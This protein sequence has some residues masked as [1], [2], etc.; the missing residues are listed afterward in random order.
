MAANRGLFLQWEGKR[1]YRQRI[2]TPRL[3][4]P[5]AEHSFGDGANMVIEGDNLQ[6]LAS[7]K[8]QYAGA[9]KLIYA[10]PP[11][12]TGQKDFR[13][14]DRRFH[15][16]DADDNDAV[17]VTNEDGGR[18]TKWLNYMAPRLSLLVDLL[19]P[20]GAVMVSIDDNEVFRLGM[21]MD[22]IFGED[23]HVATFIW[24][25]HHSRN[26]T[27]KHVAVT[28]DYILMY[29]KDKSQL[30]VRHVSFEPGEFAN[31]DNDPKGPW[32]SRDLS[33]NH[34]YAGGRYK[35]K[36]PGGRVFGPTKGRYWSLTEENFWDLHKAK[37]IWWGKE[38]NSRPR[39]KIYESELDDDPEAVPMTIWPAYEVG[40]N[41]E[42][43]SQVRDL[44]FPDASKHSPKP[45]RLIKRCI[46]LLCE[47]DEQALVLDAFAGTGTTGHAVMDLNHEDNGNRRFILIEQGIPTDRYCRT[48][49]AARL[50]N[51]IKMNHYKDGFTFYTTGR[52][53]D[54]TAIAQLEREALVSL[55]CQADETG[56]GRGIT[57]LHGHKYIIGRNHRSEAIC[58]VWNG[59]GKG[60][61]TK[62]HLKQAAQEVTDTGLKKPFRIYGTFCLVADT[63]R[64]KFCQIPDEI[65]AQM[66]IM[67]D[68]E[69]ED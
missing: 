22:E 37:R 21:L 29:A 4:E 40:H 23:N 52:K 59:G 32:V 30:R 45:V 65:L 24:Q 34:F 3:L 54:R 50:K 27:A 39:K 16:P 63:P 36:A 47:K 38:K 58:L 53:I 51:V 48:L 42:A 60:E 44:G 57:R 28:H 62:E 9:V 66:H 7:L 69:D 26:N 11:Y 18:H 8:A 68:L 5:V 15:D 2:P 20:D 64:W 61:V 13:Y 17:Y 55:I 19:R 46:E 33:A 14:S 1:V 10:D 49:T 25:K 31:P 41:Q 12:N 43:T 6:V 56:R 67:E 35:V